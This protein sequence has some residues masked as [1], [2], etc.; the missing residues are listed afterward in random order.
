MLSQACYRDFPSQQQRSAVQPLRLLHNFWN[1][2]PMQPRDVN[3]SGKPSDS[4]SWS[5]LATSKANRIPM[6]AIQIRIQTSTSVRISVGPLN[7]NAKPKQRSAIS[8]QPRCH[9]W[10]C[11]SHE[12]D[13]YLR[14]SASQTQKSSQRNTTRIPNTCSNEIELNLNSAS[15]LTN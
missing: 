13:L 9:F 7:N 5:E 11:P 15:Q 6:K 1:F 4:S 8:S 14:I 12:T 10:I 2:K 3:L